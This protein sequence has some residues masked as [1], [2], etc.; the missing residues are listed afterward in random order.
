MKL[1]D[2]RIDGFGAWSDLHLEGLAPGLNVFYG[3]NEAGKTTLMQFVR[4][5]LYGFSQERRSKYLPPV[6]GGRGGGSLTLETDLGRFTLE[7]YDDQPETEPRGRLRILD[8]QG[9]PQ[10]ENLL[11]KLVGNVDEL[12]Y[13]N[14]FAVGL[15]EL[16]E[17]GTLNDT[18]A[19]R[20]LYELASGMDRVS[21]LEVMRELQSSRQR[22]LAPGPK[23]SQVAELLRRRDTLQAELKQYQN[24]TVRYGKLLREREQMQQAQVA[25]ERQIAELQ[26]GLKRL[27]VA[28]SL[29]EVW[30]QRSDVDALL[31]EYRGLP[32]LP[33]GALDTLAQLNED[34]QA[35]KDRAQQ[36]Q[37]H[38][39]ELRTTAD[40]LGVDEN[41]LRLAPRIETL[42]Q[43]Q[44]QFVALQ[45]RVTDLT[46]TVETVERDL[47]AQ[48]Q[49]LGLGDA[50][51]EG[52][53]DPSAFKKLWPLVRLAR[54]T[55]YLERKAA[56][57]YER[58][59]LQTQ[60]IN[61]QVSRE[62]S[63]R[64]ETEPRAALRDATQQVQLLRRRAQLAER[65]RK[66]NRQHQDLA[67]QYADLLDRQLLPSGLMFALAA[68]FALGVGL[69]LA[70]LLTP[71]VPDSIGWA[72]SLLG[73]LGLSVAIFAKFFWESGQELRLRGRHKKVLSAETQ[74]AQ[75]GEDLRQIDA[76]LSTS[77]LAP[78]QRLVE[79]EKDLLRI[80]KLVPTAH[81]REELRRLS[82]RARRRA[83]KTRL[84]SRKARKRYRR[85]LVRLGLPPKTGPR[86][87]RKRAQSLLVLATK[88][89]QLSEQREVLAQ[90]R[91]ALVAIAAQ[92]GDVFDQLQ[93]TPGSADP[94]EQMRQLSELLRKQKALQ[95]HQ[96]ELR[97]EHKQGKQDQA[98]LATEVTEAE[99]RR[100]QFLKEVGAAH[101][102]DLRALIAKHAERAELQS[103]RETLQRKIELGLRGIGREEDLQVDLESTTPLAQRRAQSQTQLEDRRKQLHDLQ[104]RQAVLLDQLRALAADRQ[105]DERR[106]E[107]VTVEAQLEQARARWQAL[108]ATSSLL[109]KVREDYEQNR[110]PETLQEASRYLERLSEGHYPRV[111]TPWEEETLH[112]DNR[113]GES[114]S[115]SVLSRGTR[116]QLFL[117][118]RLAL[119]AWFA[120]RNVQLPLVL[121]DLL[122]NFDGAR[123]DAAVE[124]FRDFAAEGR[125][126]L[127][128]TCHTHL[129]ET[130]EKLGASMRPLPDRR[131]IAARRPTGERKFLPNSPEV[132]RRPETP[133][134]VPERRVSP[135]LAPAP[136]AAAPLSSPAAHSPAPFS[137]APLDP[138]AELPPSPL[139]TL[140]ARPAEAPRSAP[141]PVLPER[142]R[143]VEVPQETETS[144]ATKTPATKTP[145]PVTKTTTNKTTTTDEVAAFERDRRQDFD[146]LVVEISTPFQD[147][148]EGREFPGTPVSAEPEFRDEDRF[149]DEDADED[150]TPLRRDRRGATHRADK[151]PRKSKG[152]RKADRKRKSE[153]AAEAGEGNRRTRR[154][155]P[156]EQRSEGAAVPPASEAGDLTDPAFESGFERVDFRRPTARP[157]REPQGFG[158]NSRGPRAEDDSAPIFHAEETDVWS[159]NTRESA[160]PL[161]D[162]DWEPNLDDAPAT[163]AGAERTPA[164]SPENRDPREPGRAP[165]GDD[166]E[167]NGPWEEIAEWD[168][169]D[170]WNDSSDAA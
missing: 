69:L 67:E 18:Q 82:E 156:P 120:R 115:F 30:R 136:P 152:H 10:P 42:E 25:C 159:T 62:L 170:E 142:T 153:Q 41:F 123:A 40:Q 166:A 1:T 84:A 43:Q 83:K 76:R 81:R 151:G 63:P 131:Q 118:L 127:V 88:L 80:E 119:A 52:L 56:A 47:N 65:Q 158:L 19:G 124:L 112:V 100:K 168:E 9:R 129:L 31:A 132:P 29:R 37:Q 109:Q 163:P 24:L 89:R 11:A 108:A 165:Q 133:L 16:Q 64:G 93:W 75:L 102:D 13:Q 71:L 74:L 148:A 125:Q 98:R 147:E 107:L 59:R 157:A 150:V 22:L 58:L 141:A 139:R 110:Q 105:A 17:L 68:V 60:E 46:R 12:V 34:L 78:E 128:F 28:E 15:R 20:Q 113:R 45:N 161:I 49:A 134:T 70:T 121:D 38:L 3:P 99:R 77:P 117:S 143:P 111:W 27:D 122:V 149:E 135:A 154:A 116:E 5:M 23:A 160:V 104:T 96:L 106:L 2:L 91:R 35:R 32:S 103:E 7:R 101:E 90:E 54:R 146:D 44:S 167:W 61:D 79:A 92:L 48:R 8:A 85:A 39:N 138:A 57:R 130:F 51:L 169:D 86:T 4:A 6:H 33:A 137:S 114:L 14:V 164:S 72:L 140:P 94:R 55:R 162:E 50:P 66:L 53:A 144:R 145:T 126:L 87:L 97:R 95:N 155:A 21:L 36:A 26:Q 73:L